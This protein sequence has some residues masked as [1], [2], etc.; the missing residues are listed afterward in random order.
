M[1][2]SMRIRVLHP[3]PFHTPSP[4]AYETYSLLP[5]STC[6]PFVALDT[7]LHSLFLVSRRQQR[8]RQMLTAP[9]P[10]PLDKASQTILIIVIIIIPPPRR[11]AKKICCS[12]AAHILKTLLYRTSYNK[13]TRAL[14]FEN[15]YSGLRCR[16]FHS[17]P[18]PLTPWTPLTPRT[19]HLLALGFCR[20]PCAER[21]T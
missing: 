9:A 17:G 18:H 13:C 6:C 11:S 10:P 21:R 7:V 2:L 4:C 3:I 15:V 19:K 16:D 5:P 1:T 20:L 12:T 14:T 8:T